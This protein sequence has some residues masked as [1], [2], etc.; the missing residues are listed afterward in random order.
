MGA[1]RGAHG[2]SALEGIWGSPCNVGERETSRRALPPSTC[3]GGRCEGTAER[4]RP[5]CWQP[6]GHSGRFRP[7]NPAS[8]LNGSQWPSRGLFLREV[9]TP[10]PLVKVER[11]GPW[12]LESWQHPARSPCR[13]WKPR[14]QHQIPLR[15]RCRRPPARPLSPR[16]VRGHRGAG[17]ALLAPVLGW[18]SLRPVS[19]PALLGRE[20]RTQPR[21]A[22]TRTTPCRGPSSRSQK[23]TSRPGPPFA[24]HK[25]S[26][27]P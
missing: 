15:K 20:T 19:T 7:G 22:L 21:G 12:G 25:G 27:A 4:W 14:Q 18:T 26:V 17:R 16:P 24:L 13:E 3:S 2:T 5:L 23:V 10:P 6:G 11:L 9:L 8:P 1:F